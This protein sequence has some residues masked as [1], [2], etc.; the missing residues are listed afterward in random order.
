LGGQARMALTYQPDAVDGLWRS[1]DATYQRTL[2]EDIY[3][4]TRYQQNLQGE[5]GRRYS[6]RLDYQ[7][8]DFT[9]GLVAYGD[10]AGQYGGQ[11]SLRTQLQP[12]AEGYEIANAMRSRSAGAATVKLLVFVDDNGNKVMD[13]GEPPMPG[14]KVMNL[15][16]SSSQISNPAGEVVFN[17]IPSNIPVRLEVDM[18]E[19]PD[20]Y[21]SAPRRPL[22]VYG[23][24]GAKGEYILPLQRL[25]EVNGTIVREGR[26]GQKIAVAGLTLVALD[27]EGKVMARTRTDGEGF[28][29]LG[30]LPLGQ[31]QIAIEADERGQKGFEFIH[32]TMQP[33]TAKNYLVEGVELFVKNR[34]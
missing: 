12:G 10:S 30:D 32:D 18:E 15:S 14:V 25:G 9:L 7:L 27:A 13:P 34:N 26:E 3:F 16:R 5:Q 11:L 23:Q 17:D 33:L 31:Y 1:M 20:I 29:I 19:I 6:G 28:F 4:S 2:T 24:A 8:S 22:V 21:L